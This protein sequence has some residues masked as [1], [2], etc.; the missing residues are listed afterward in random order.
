MYDDDHEAQGG[1]H[2]AAYLVLAALIMLGVLLG[3]G[4]WALLLH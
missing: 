1:V 2:L 4:V 3:G